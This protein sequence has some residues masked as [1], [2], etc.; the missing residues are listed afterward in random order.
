MADVEFYTTKV[1]LEV[2]VSHQFDPVSGINCVVS[3][4]GY[5]AIQGI[6]IISAE[7]NFWPFSKPSA[8]M[9]PAA[10]ISTRALTVVHL[11]ES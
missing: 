11:L 7:S 8:E 10:H 4:L 2:E 5:P 6:R 9:K 3:M 1:L